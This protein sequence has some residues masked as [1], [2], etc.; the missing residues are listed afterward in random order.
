MHSATTELAAAD[1]PVVTGKLESTKLRSDVRQRVQ[2]AIEALRYEVTVGDVAARAGISL[3][4][5]EEALTALAADS[6]GTLK[7]GSTTEEQR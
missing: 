4:E 7:V 1:N 3:A 6:L 2:D 5:A